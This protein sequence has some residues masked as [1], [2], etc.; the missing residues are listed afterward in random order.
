MNPQDV[1]RPGTQNVCRGSNHPPKTS[2]KPRVHDISPNELLK[3][4]NQKGYRQ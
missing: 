3:G 4:R 2:K 1:G